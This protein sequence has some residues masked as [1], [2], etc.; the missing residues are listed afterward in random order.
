[1][2][3]PDHLVPVGTVEDFD[4]VARVAGNDVAHCSHTPDD[5]PTGIGNKDAVA[6]AQG[7]VAGRVGA[8]EVADD[9]GKTVGLEQDAAVGEA[10]DGQA[11]HDAAARGDPQPDD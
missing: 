6:V 5:V 8:D 1:D 7:R 4:A 3:V 9:G 11:A 10:I 2:G